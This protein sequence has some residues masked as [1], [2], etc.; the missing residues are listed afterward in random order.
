MSIL[1][2]RV[3]K[4][5]G[6]V[7]TAEGILQVNRVI[8]N[9]LAMLR[10]GVRVIKAA[11]LSDFDKVISC[12]DLTLLTIEEQEQISIYI[13]PFGL[14]SEGF[15]YKLGLSTGPGSAVDF[16]GLAC[17]IKAARTLTAARTKPE[18]DIRT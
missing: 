14:L 16:K 8:F 3:Y 13:G 12:N 18:S 2:Q 1:L 6:K 7:N 9:R 11:I 15:V 5:A 17:E 10:R 4:L